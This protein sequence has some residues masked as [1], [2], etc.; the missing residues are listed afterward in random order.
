MHL[1]TVSEVQVVDVQKR[2]NPSKHYDSV[3]LPLQD[4]V[5]LPLQDFVGLPL[6]D[7]VQRK[8][9]A[10]VT[11]GIGFSQIAAPSPQRWRA[12]ASGGGNAL[13]LQG[14]SLRA[15]KI[16]LPQRSF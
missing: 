16:L 11:E 3:G 1:R 12:P 4:F 7:F 2:R 13:F 5:G 9:Q 6:Q 14:L 8:L 10:D 15:R